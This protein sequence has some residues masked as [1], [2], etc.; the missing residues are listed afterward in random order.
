M[1]NVNLTG[2][3]FKPYKDRGGTVIFTHYIDIVRSDQF[4]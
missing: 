4:L 3:K 1:P 2:F